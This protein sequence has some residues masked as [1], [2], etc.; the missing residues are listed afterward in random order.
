MQRTKT[1]SLRALFRALILAPALAVAAQ[2]AVLQ[3]PPQSVVDTAAGISLMRYWKEAN[4][5]A[6]TNGAWYGG[7]SITLAV[8]SYAGNTTADAALFRQ[9]R[10]SITGGNEP[11]ANGGYP[12]QHE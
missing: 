7:A 10:Y 11:C 12:A 3:S 6:Y 5:G 1:R 8:A 2:A 9:I 4:G